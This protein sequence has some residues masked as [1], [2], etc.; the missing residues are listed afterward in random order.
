VLEHIMSNL[1]L[2]QVIII[3]TVII[4]LTALLTSNYIWPDYPVCTVC[5]CTG[6]PTTLEAP[7]QG[8]RQK[9]HWAKVYWKKSLSVLR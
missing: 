9:C 8:K 6:G 3:I 2:Q 1:E 4:T 7:P 5:T